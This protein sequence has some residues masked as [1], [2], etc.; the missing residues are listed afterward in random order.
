MLAKCGITVYWAFSSNGCV[1]KRIR[2]PRPRFHFIFFLFSSAATQN[3]SFPLEW[4][5][6][7]GKTCFSPNVL[8][9]FLFDFTIHIATIVFQMMMIT[10]LRCSHN[11]RFHVLFIRLF[12]LVSSA[13]GHIQ[14]A[15]I[16]FFA[17]FVSNSR[18]LYILFCI[19]RSLVRAT[20]YQIL[21]A[22]VRSLQTIIIKNLRWYFF[23]HPFSFTCHNFDVKSLQWIDEWEA[24]KQQHRCQQKKW[25]AWR[26][27]SRKCKLFAFLVETEVLSAAAN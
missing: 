25:T 7:G 19:I 8:L 26:T 6:C 27:N 22:A 10:R 15:V 14:W 17:S 16:Y 3:N 11:I 20:N 5:Q 4:I 2:W 21:W 12:C 18:L 24:R 9:S 1:P 13:T 23:N